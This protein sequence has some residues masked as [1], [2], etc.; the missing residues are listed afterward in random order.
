MSPPL[1]WFDADLT[2]NRPRSASEKNPTRFRSSDRIDGLGRGKINPSHP[3]LIQIKLLGFAWFYSSELGLFNGLQQFQIKNS[4]SCP[5]PSR[6]GGARPARR[7][8]LS[9][10]PIARLSRVSTSTSAGRPLSDAASREST[11]A[12]TIAF[13]QFGT[14]YDIFC[15]SERECRKNLDDRIIIY[16]LYN[17]VCHPDNFRVIPLSFGRPQ[18]DR[19]IGALTV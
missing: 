10:E 7:D 9:V 16:L 8:P 15:L 6:Q 5:F 19:Q 18:K 4:P 12:V 1:N 17:M 3:K 14:S 13:S 2:T 11:I